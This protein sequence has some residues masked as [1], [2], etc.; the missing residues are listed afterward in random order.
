MPLLILCCALLVSSFLI[1]NEL[2]RDN[3]GDLDSKFCML[4]AEREKGKFN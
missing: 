2:L 1:R 4:T 3:A